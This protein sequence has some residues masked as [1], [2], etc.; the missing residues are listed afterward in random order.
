MFPIPPPKHQLQ[1]R[2]LGLI[3]GVLKK[4]SNS[5]SGLL[6]TE[7]GFEYPAT[8]GRAQLLKP[9]SYCMET[10]QPHWFFVQPQPRPQQVL[11]LSVIRILS[12]SETELE[13]MGWLDTDYDD[14]FPAIVNEA[15]E[16]FNIRGTIRSRKAS[17]TVSLKRKPQGKKQF[18]PLLIEVQGFLPGAE[19]GEFWDLQVDREGHD[20]VLM[21]G[22]KLAEA[23]HLDQQ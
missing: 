6:C 11:G 18:P 4:Q 22:A 20:L 5:Y 13:A 2:A 16:G 1:Y 12:L 8:P 3:K 21:D 15:E 14:P 10:A 23:P 17:V 19:D 9:F 7:D